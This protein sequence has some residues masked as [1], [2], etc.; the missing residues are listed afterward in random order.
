MA[1]NQD[2]SQS[3][4]PAGERKTL[5]QVL[6]VQFGLMFASSS[7][8]WALTINKGMTFTDTLICFVLGHFVV[9]WLFFFNGWLGVRERLSTIYLVQQAFGRIGSILVTLLL[10]FSL[11]GWMG[12]QVGSTGLAIHAATG[13]NLVI[14][15]IVLGVAMTLTAA[16]GFKALA[17]LS[18][19]AVPYFV[20]VCAIGIG[21]AM[22]QLGGLDALLLYQPTGSMSMSS[23]ITAVVG[24][25]AVMGLITSDIFRYGKSMKDMT[26]SVIICFVVG[27]MI[28]PLA[29]VLLAIAAGSSDLGI[30]V[31]SM[32]G[33]WG[34]SML[35]LSGW[36]T[37][38]NDLY[39]AALA[40]SA[41]TEKISKTTC[42][43][44]FGL[45]GTTAAALGITGMI[46]PY[47]SI[48]SALAPP[49]FGIMQAD[50]WTLPKLL[51]IPRG[52]VL[53]KHKSVNVSAV[54]AWGIAIACFYLL[55]FGVPVINGILAAFISYIVLSVISKASGFWYVG[56]VAPEQDNYP[57]P[58]EDTPINSYIL[59]DQVEQTTA[60]TM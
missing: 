58:I 40:L 1:V 19:I 11:I 8:L 3:R 26:L 56:T 28:I 5:W 9:F 17:F 33:W 36:T 12:V 20:L 34:V 51:G 46:I 41:L 48:L 43:V 29:G 18:E 35:F 22:K 13:W 42:A 54:I 27:H 31:W 6:T 23:G 38:D 44:I 2:F 39:S 37:G 21:L 32:L 60:Y 57:A 4:V 10:I 24:S 47:L 14:V 25:I 52:D 59:A 50:Y 45:I 30:V 53:R 7:L 55:P 16:I 49:I 15:N